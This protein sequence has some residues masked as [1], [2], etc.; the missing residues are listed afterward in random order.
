MR[1]KDWEL[2]DE[3]DLVIVG[4]GGAS[5]CAALAAK[6]LGKRPVILEKQSVVGGSTS[7]SGGVWWVPDNPLLAGAG[8]EDSFDKAHEYLANCVDHSGPAVTEERTRAFLKSAP[9]MVA[10]LQSLGV[11]I[12]RPT[13]AWPDYYDDLPGGVPEGRSLLAEPFDMHQLGEYEP[14]L[15]MHPMM[16]T[17]PFGV[18]EVP[19]LFLLKRNWA[20]KRKAVKFALMTVLNKLLGRRIVANGAAIQGQMVKVAVEHDIPFFRD[21]PV[22]DLIVADNRVIGVKATYR[23]KPVEVR[24]RD[25][26][27]VN[28]GGFSRNDDMRKRYGHQPIN[29]GWTNANPGDTGELMRAMMALGAATDCLDTA[30]W[31]MTSFAPDGSWPKGAQQNGYPY[32]FMHILDTSFPHGIIVDRDGRRMVNESGSYQEVG[33]K[34]FERHLKTGRGLPAWAIMDSRH[35]KRYPWGTLPPGVT[36]KE[37]IETGYMKKA[38]S[39]EELAAICGI[40]PVGLKDEVARFNGFAQ[41]GVDQDFNR[42]GRAFD[43]SHGDPTVSPNP[44]LGEIAEPPF[45]AVALHHGDVGT[46]GGVVTD[47]FAR[48]R[49]ADGSVIS[50]LYAAGNV[51]ASPFGRTYPGAGAS[52]SSA[53]TFGYIAAHHMAKSNKLIDLVG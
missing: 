15:A 33:E 5:F 44:N 20:G 36:P 3:Y 48:V 17:L 22:D 1:L 8:V 23:G 47:E 40:N 42:G 21:V 26:V 4:S 39:L 49:R 45:Y 28:A 43:R 30:V 13:D 46:S 50:G 52:I 31:C 24:A 38:G 11:R 27:L 25:G 18:D 37:W 53:F 6:S 14:W 51:A 10:F 35:R 32:P 2:Q 9:R 12:R 16:T 19:T 29:A 41:S 7:F 34:I